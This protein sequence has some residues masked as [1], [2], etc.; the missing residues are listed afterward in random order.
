MQKGDIVTLSVTAVNLEGY[1]IAKLNSGDADT[2][3]MYTIYI[4][5]SAPHDSITAEIQSCEKNRATASII[6]ILQPSHMRNRETL[7]NYYGKCGGCQLGH[8]MPQYQRAIKQDWMIKLFQNIDT[9][10]CPAHANGFEIKSGPEYGYRFRAQFFKNKHYEPCFRARSSA[11]A[12]P[13]TECPVLAPSLNTWLK[14]ATSVIK[15]NAAIPERFTVTASEDQVFIE[16]VN[17]EAYAD[18]LHKHIRYSPECFF[19]S[20]H[21]LLPELIEDVCRDVSGKRALDLYAG[22]GLFSIFLQQQFTKIDC[23]ESSIASTQW[24]SQNCAHAGV[25]AL[26]AESWIKT[27]AAQ[28]DYDY[29]VV[30]PPRN[31][32]SK[33]IRTWLKQ[34]RI[35]LLGYVSCNPE[36][37]ARDASDLCD[38]GYTLTELKFYDFYPHTTEMEAYAR[39]ISRS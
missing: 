37:L 21:I 2:E 31:G 15:N 39:F 7:C 36:T 26:S 9:G 33:P 32:L 1:G 6:S 14:E 8:I 38:H 4:P 12:I 17:R 25:Y 34:K 22:V 29:V 20:N 27:A 23:V 10:A 5:Y 11:E 35:P 24:I 13:V 3:Q 19:Q 30:D 18:I 28:N 16:G